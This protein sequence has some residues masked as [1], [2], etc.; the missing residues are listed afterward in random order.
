MCSVHLSPYSDFTKKYIGPVSDTTGSRSGSTTNILPSCTGSTQ[1]LHMSVVWAFTLKLGDLWDRGRGRGWSRLFRRLP[2]P[3]PAQM[4]RGRAQLC[5]VPRRRC[6][7]A[8][9]SPARRIQGRPGNNRSLSYEHRK[10]NIKGTVWPDW[11]CMRVDHWIGH[12]KD[13]NRYRFLVF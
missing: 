8:A 4:W 12:E 10:R 6:L 2:C 9:R 3:R 13:I 5:A 7:P 1:I 11:I